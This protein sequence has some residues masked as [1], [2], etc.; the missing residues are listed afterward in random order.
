MRKIKKYI[1]ELYGWKFN[2]VLFKVIFFVYVSKELSFCVVMKL[3]IIDV[4]IMKDLL[5]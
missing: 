4:I 2:Y 3:F 1:L 5:L